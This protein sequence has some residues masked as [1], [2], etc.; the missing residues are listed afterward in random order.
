MAKGEAAKKLFNSTV[1]RLNSGAERVG[2]KPKRLAE[3][4]TSDKKIR[5]TASEVFLKNDKDGKNFANLYTG[6]KVRGL[7]MLAIGGVGVAATAGVG[8]NTATG[9]EGFM[10]SGTGLMEVRRMTTPRM[11]TM[12]S[13]ELPTFLADGG[14][15]NTTSNTLGA[16]GDMVFGMHNRR[17]G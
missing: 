10:G 13:G 17:K 14:S 16:S 8:G 4:M 1:K 7:P 3:A 11:G 5:N 9:D 15:K 6:K 2:S 12:E